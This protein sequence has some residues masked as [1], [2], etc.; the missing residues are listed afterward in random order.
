MT[1][2][3]DKRDKEDIAC[4]D[5]LVSVYGCAAWVHN[6]RLWQEGGRESIK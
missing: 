1:S 6:L 5:P 2:G 4:H 3:Q